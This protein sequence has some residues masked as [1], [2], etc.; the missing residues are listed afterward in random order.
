MVLSATSSLCLLTSAAAA[1]ASPCDQGIAPDA[2]EAP[3][4]GALDRCRWTPRW[5]FCYCCVEWPRALGSCWWA[6]RWKFGYG[7]VE[8]PWVRSRSRHGPCRNWRLP[9]VGSLFSAGSRD[10]VGLGCAAPGTVR[11]RS[12]VTASGSTWCSSCHS[13]WGDIGSSAAQFLQFVWLLLWRTLSKGTVCTPYMSR[14]TAE[15]A[16]SLALA[17]SSIHDGGVRSMDCSGQLSGWPR[18]CIAVALRDPHR[19]G[20]ER[21]GWHTA[22]PLVRLINRGPPP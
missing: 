22:P 17:H 10:W 21:L 3:H 4:Q 6:P 20:H 11:G 14:S 7:C 16:I 2:A 8:Y 19:R 15:V 18:S 13:W 12:P 9:L 1:T 5:Q